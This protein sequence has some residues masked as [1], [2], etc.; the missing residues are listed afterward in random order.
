MAEGQ[1]IVRRTTESE[2]RI[3]DRIIWDDALSITARFSLIAMLSLRKG[4]DYSVRG[5][6]KMLGLSKD[7][8]GKYIR[9]LESAGYLKRLQG[10][11]ETG[12]FAKAKYI[13]TDTPWCFG[14]EE[15][16]P[17]NSDAEEPCPN[18]P[19]PKVPYP[20][21]SPQQNN[22]SKQQKRIKEDSPLPPKGEKGPGKPKAKVPAGETPKKPSKYALAEDAKPI[23]R[24]YVGED[25]ELAHALA[26][27]IEI[28]EKIRAVNSA[29][30]IRLLLNELDKLSGGRREDK[31]LIL[32]QSIMNSWKS[33][34][35]L[36]RD[37]GSGTPPGVQ[38][39]PEPT[40]WGWD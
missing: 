38:A 29:K 4:W 14:E 18:F 6:A 40:H 13:L 27:L 17:K 7:T 1:I 16:C 20:E 12:K 15:P 36:K 26:D 3:Q 25:L 21:K 8:M 11:G 5:M 10:C 35:P 22:D 30:A 37:F 23:L 34:F 33:V 39:A 9:E 31:L 32:R 19:D 2:T 28:R 24:S